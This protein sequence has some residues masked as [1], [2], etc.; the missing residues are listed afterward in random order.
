MILDDGRKLVGV[1]VPLTALPVLRQHLREAVE[2]RKL[3]VEGGGGGIIE[4]VVPLD[5]KTLTQIKTPPKNIHSYFGRTSSCGDSTASSPVRGDK[6]Q[7]PAATPESGSLTGRGTRISQKRRRGSVVEKGGQQ[8]FE[9]AAKGVAA[10]FGARAST[11]SAAADVGDSNS[12][13]NGDQNGNFSGEG[14]LPSAKA[15]EI[16]AIDD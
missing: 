12:V 11:G 6:R 1:R 16:I 4:P 14:Q 13:L 8:K 3:V 7:A 2:A 5:P 10:L 15:S 9:S